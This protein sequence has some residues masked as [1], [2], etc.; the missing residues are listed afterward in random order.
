[1][2]VRSDDHKTAFFHYRLVL[3]WQD[4]RFIDSNFT[5]ADAKKCFP[6][7]IRP[8]QVDDIWKPDVY[9]DGTMDGVRLDIIIRSNPFSNNYINCSKATTVTRCDLAA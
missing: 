4:E 9:I 5:R 2:Y 8:D 1:M 3:I 7:T 6:G